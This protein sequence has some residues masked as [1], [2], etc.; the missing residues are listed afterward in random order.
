MELYVV[1]TQWL[2]Y[3]SEPSYMKQNN[4]LT[5]HIIQ[6]IL[7][8]KIKLSRYV[9]LLNVCCVYQPYW[10][11]KRWIVYSHYMDIVYVFNLENFYSNID[12]NKIFKVYYNTCYIRPNHLLLD[13][14]M[15]PS[16]NSKDLY[17]RYCID[18]YS[19]DL[20]NFNKT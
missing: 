5:N 20:L 9:A 16:D 15:L 14:S 19:R 11:R 8:N 1:D 4:T 3:I 2:W 7:Y 12:G 10:T 17:S 18:M 13:F 6:N